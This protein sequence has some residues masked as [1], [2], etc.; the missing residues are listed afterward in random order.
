MDAEKQKAESG[1]DHQEKTKI[2]HEAESKV[3]YKK[4]TISKNFSTTIFSSTHF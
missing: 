4:M 2:F 3:S 1:A